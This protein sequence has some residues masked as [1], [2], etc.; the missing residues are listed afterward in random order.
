[1]P[2]PEFSEFQ[3]AYGVTKEIELRRVKIPSLGFP[4]F[5]T[6]NLEGDIGFDVAFPHGAS[7]LCLQYKRSKRLDD[8]RARDEEWETYKDTYYRFGIRTSD[9]TGKNTED[10]Q[11]EIL[12]DLANK[13]PNTYYVAPEF[14][15]LSEYSRLAQVDQ[16]MDNAA[17]IECYGAPV[18][19]DNDNHVICHRPQD[20]V[21][22]LFSERPSEQELPVNRGLETIL[23]ISDERGPQFEDEQ[24]LRNAFRSVRSQIAEQ[25]AVDI[26]PGEYESERLIRWMSLQQQ[27]FVETADVSLYFV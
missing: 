17:F 7:P 10:M 14:I 20:N 13:F 9:Q 18:P 26:D 23:S 25:R 5:P 22:L 24:E 21:A 2:K 11:H 27:F 12:V 8:A 6:Q 4:W 3:F 16:L 15:T 19:N 1:M